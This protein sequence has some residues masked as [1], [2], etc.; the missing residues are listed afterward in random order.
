MAE[1]Q[2]NKLQIKAEILTVLSQ[3][4]ANLEAVNIDKVLGNLI[5]QE[6]KKS[7]LD[8][9]IKELSKS[10]EQK[11][12]LVCFLL[13]KLCEKDVLEEALWGVLKNQS[14]SDSTKA[15][16]LN[17]LKD[18][19]NK[20]EYEK[21]DEYFEN[22]NE[23]IDADT[24]RLLQA[25]IINPEAQIDFI[26]FLNSLSDNDQKI[27]VQSLG[28]D[29]SSDSLANI[30]NPVVMYNSTCELGK[31]SIDILGETKSQLAL[32]GLSEA[33]KFTDDEETG[34]LIKRNIS[35][36][37]ISGVR[38]DNSIEFY[39]SILSSKPYSSYAS[40]PDG[41][42]NQAII[43]SRERED[44]TIQMFAVVI[45][46]TFGL[47]DC[48]GFNQIA[49]SELERIVHK[50]YNDDEHIYLNPAV[51]KTLLKDAEKITRK[52]GNKVSY[53]YLC[54][55]ILL[56]DIQIEPVPIE[57]ILKSKYSQ[58]P[59]TE[60][61]LEKIYLFDFI[62]KWF[63]DIEYNE[64]FNSL[65]SHLNA[66]MGSNDFNFD[67]EEV[68]NKYFDKIFT[69]QEKAALDKRILMSSYLK[70]LSE[71]K[72]NAAEEAQLLYSLY[73]DEENKIKL[74]ENIIKKS[75]Y[76][77]YVLLKFKYKEKNKTTNIF[78]MRNKQK[79]FELTQKQVDLAISVIEGLWV[80]NGK[81]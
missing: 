21:L 33:L 42:G 35:K 78:T 18:M 34:L 16:I 9:L 74:S 52:T 51:I 7:I 48:F 23:V 36:L 29:Y 50:F 39:K 26:D 25:A 41:H 27:L 3:L 24:K 75:I 32:H 60:I 45:N 37:K 67:F 56:A 69:V 76:E 81:R 53:E 15:I 28:E 30:L 5:E 13:L 40:F 59:L 57:L 46:D 12:I 61:E 49:K 17:V 20:V 14:V 71:G 79:D 19:G 55:E 6:D 22:P 31:I 62:Q 63:F 2:L 68:I 73:Y 44:E 47:I 11:S 58:K 77:Y 65:I 10:N 80:Q 72:Q 43:F 70:Y 38:E 64:G 54:W 66:K 4:Q 8:V 1:N